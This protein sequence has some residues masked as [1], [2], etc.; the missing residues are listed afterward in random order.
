M[1]KLS[2]IILLVFISLT[3]M[4]QMGNNV[5]VYDSLRNICDTIR[6]PYEQERVY[7]E[8]CNHASSTDFVFLYSMKLLNL[9]KKLD[10]K[11]Y[12]GVANGL[13]AWVYQVQNNFD[14]SLEY[15]MQSIQCYKDCDSTHYLLMAYN[16]LGSIYSNMNN[17]GASLETFRLALKLAQE[18][19]DRD[20]ERAASNYIGYVYVEMKLFRFAMDYLIDLKPDL[21][22]PNGFRLW[23]DSQLGLMEA[24]LGL[25]NNG[26]G[27]SRLDAAY[28]T[29]KILQEDTLKSLSPITYLNYTL[30]APL[31]YIEKSRIRDRKKNLDSAS[32]ILR[33]GIVFA[34]NHTIDIFEPQHKLLQCLILMEKR[35]YD[36]VPPFLNELDT[37][38]KQHGKN[39]LLDIM[40]DYYKIRRDYPKILEVM[41]MKTK[42]FNNK[43][44][45]DF[46][47]RS[48]NSKAVDS[49]NDE[50]ERIAN[51]EAEE[52]RIAE[53]TRKNYSYIKYI[54][55]L[56]ILFLLIL[57]VYLVFNSRAA[58][59]TNLIMAAQNIKLK[60]TTDDLTNAQAEYQKQCD[61]ILEQ[62]QVLDDQKGYMKRMNRFLNN[63]LQSAMTMQRAVVP[64]AEAIGKIVGESFV[65]WRPLDS[66]SGDFY[67]SA[68]RGA[69]KFLIVADCTGHGVPGALLSILGTSILNSLLPQLY[70]LDAAQILEL[71]KS[72]FKET[73]CKNTNI[74][75]GMDLA[76]VVF[77]RNNIIQY[78]GANRPLLIVRNG[79]LIEYKPDRI[80]IGNNFYKEHLTFT[81]HKIEVQPGDMLYAFSDGVT[82]Q[83]GGISGKQKYSIKALKTLLC[84]IAS[85]PV[86]TQRQYI[87]TAID[88]WRRHDLEGSKMYP[89]ID[90]ELVVGVR[91]G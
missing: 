24:N 89:Q 59:K 42:L 69:R 4:G 57:G 63:G 79:E 91:V 44:R 22:T 51:H 38:I 62:T 29:T 13:L 58:R 77:E 88:E 45:M 46:A 76:L 7:A 12:Q 16:T 65:F 53:N 23:V 28:K 17:I 74:D 20:M 61:E 81:N 78:A 39:Q 60:Q 66:V 67:W 47:M 37:T 70:N 48:E 75:D 49:Y 80:C 90:D 56:G 31:V 3:S 14:K 83:F 26:D 32:E 2:A 5:A 72:K 71:Y 8:M 64:S 27:I 10:D 33:R 35:Y 52:I 43:Y 86:E 55:I 21:A 19:G 84:E 18:S 68:R 82:D 9:S 6:N 73:I 15:G 87:G 36:L 25:Y 54:C 50:M 11:F 41:E 30:L 34:S 40:Y 1:K 85:L